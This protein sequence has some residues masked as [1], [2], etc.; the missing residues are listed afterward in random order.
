VASVRKNTQ[1]FAGAVLANLVA[2]RADDLFRELLWSD[3]IDAR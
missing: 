3:A 1:Q 2:V